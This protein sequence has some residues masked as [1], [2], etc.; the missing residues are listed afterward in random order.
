MICFWLV[1]TPGFWDSPRDWPAG[2]RPVVFSTELVM[3]NTGMVQVPAAFAAEVE[4][5]LGTH[6]AVL[7][8]T[9]PLMAR[10]SH[11]ESPRKA[12]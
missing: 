8:V 9:R 12:A 2:C 5:R 7:S 10:V 11:A 6:P 4:H 1:V 3:R